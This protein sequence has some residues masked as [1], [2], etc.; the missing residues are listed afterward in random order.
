[1]KYKNI[2]LKTS[3]LSSTFYFGFF[4]CWAIQECHENVSK[5]NA[6]CHIVQERE[7]NIELENILSPS[8]PILISLGQT[9]S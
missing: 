8:K 6:V 7:K 3:T 9:H 1:M 4:S 2:K 5:T